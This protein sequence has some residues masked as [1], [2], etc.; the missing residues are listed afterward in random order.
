MTAHYGRGYGGQVL[1]VVP[2]RDLTVVMTSDPTPPSNGSYFQR[3]AA[4]VQALIEAS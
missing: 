3:Q 1:F 4:I 2:A